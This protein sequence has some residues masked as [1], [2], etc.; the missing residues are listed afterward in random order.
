MDNPK[1]KNIAFQ[2]NCSD[3]FSPNATAIM[4]LDQSL[5]DYMRDCLETSRKIF[6]TS[7]DVFYIVFSMNCVQYFTY[8]PK[9]V[10]DDLRISEEEF[11]ELNQNDT[12]RITLNKGVEILPMNT[13][14]I[15]IYQTRPDD[16]TISA[17]NK[18]SGDTYWFNV[19]FKDLEEIFSAV[20]EVSTI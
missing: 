3:E 19:S 15:R 2:T 1:I 17:N 9:N 8:I 12:L 5:L 13:D 10:L 4:F 14:E 18:F 20:P 16:L 7:K 6:E 11:V